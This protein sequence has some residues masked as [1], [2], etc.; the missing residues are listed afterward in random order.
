MVRDNFVSEDEVDHWGI[1]GTG[2]QPHQILCQSVQGF[3]SSDNRNLAL[4]I[5]SPGHSYNSVRTAILC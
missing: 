3:C 2:N 4:S 5:G 1:C